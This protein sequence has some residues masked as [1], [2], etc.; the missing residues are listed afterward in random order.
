MCY[1]DKNDSYGDNMNN[2]KEK[3]F[4]KSKVIMII[5][6][7]LLVIG[8]IMLIANIAA[9]QKAKRVYEEQYDIWFDKWWNDKT[10]TL[11]DMPDNPTFDMGG[12]IVVSI[13]W[14]IISLA[15]TFVGAGPF[16]NK[17][18]IALDAEIMTRV[19]I[20]KREEQVTETKVETETTPARRRKE[21]EHCGAKL[22]KGSYT[23][24]YCGKEN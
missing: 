9:F 16:L 11:N 10:A 2:K 18:K 7:I 13:F 17:N 14:I 8:I 12:G 6:I 23:C 22:N 4:K 24:D 15:I 5:G 3:N 21:C 19:N 20:E 1:N